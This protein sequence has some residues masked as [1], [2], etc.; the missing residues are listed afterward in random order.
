MDFRMLSDRVAVIFS[1]G[2][3]GDAAAAN[4][5]TTIEELD[6]AL[7]DFSWS[8]GRKGRPKEIFVGFSAVVGGKWDSAKFDLAAK[9]RNY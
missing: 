3:S 6:R 2:A 8:F 7:D 4:A 9:V 5:A 1:K